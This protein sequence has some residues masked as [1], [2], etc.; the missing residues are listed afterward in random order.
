LDDILIFGT[1]IVVINDVKSFLSQ[2]FDLKDLGEADVILNIKLI[3]G[4]NGIILKQSHYVENILNRYGFSDSKDSP[5]P[6]DPSL[7]LRNNRGQGINQLRYF[8]IISSL[9]YLASAT[10]PDILFVGVH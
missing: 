8:Q 3:K 10:R 2:N 5:T 4:E 7:K 9:M 6:F 1:N